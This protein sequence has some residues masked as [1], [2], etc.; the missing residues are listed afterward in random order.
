MRT[1]LTF[2]GL[3]VVITATRSPQPVKRPAIITEVNGYEITAV[4]TSGEE[5]AFLAD[6]LHEGQA[7]T[8][9]IDGCNTATLEDDRV[10]DIIF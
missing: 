7:V 10:I 8:L 9:V 4:D 5:W 3:L 6:E 1:W 2:F